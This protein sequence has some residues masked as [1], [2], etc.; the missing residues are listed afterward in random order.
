MV[1]FK[2][3]STLVNKYL[4]DAGFTIHDLGEH[5][6]PGLFFAKKKPDI[7]FYYFTIGVKSKR[8]AQTNL[9]TYLELVEI[10]KILISEIHAHTPKDGRALN[11][12]MVNSIN[13]KIYFS[14][15]NTL[16]TNPL[17]VECP[18]TGIDLIQ[19]GIQLNTKH[20]VC[21]GVQLFGSHYI[22]PE[23]IPT[24]LDPSSQSV[25]GVIKPG[26]KKLVVTEVAITC[27]KR[28]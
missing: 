20:S 25:R 21:R 24:P 10:P 4:A 6:F 7:S 8:N 1:M 5:I 9:P 23:Y 15:I 17:I 14:D 16:L 22:Y 18:I 27:R 3:E 2:K 12:M 11:I 13:E 26:V 19:T 28:F